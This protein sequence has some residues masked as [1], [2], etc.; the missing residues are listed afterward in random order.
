[1]MSVHCGFQGGAGAGN[2]LPP[3]RRTGKNVFKRLTGQ[4]I[5]LSAGRLE[6]GT[7][8][9][10]RTETRGV[11]LWLPARLDPSDG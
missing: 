10:G 3:F 8:G 9:L 5:R 4:Q 6:Q 2:L 11:V 7:L 1:M